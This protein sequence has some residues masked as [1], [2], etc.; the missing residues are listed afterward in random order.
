[1]LSSDFHCKENDGTIWFPGR[2]RTS[3][4]CVHEVGVTVYGVQ[5]V[6]HVQVWPE[7]QIVPSFSL[8]W[9]SD[10]STKHYL[11]QMLLAINWRYLQA[12][13]NSRMRTKV[14]YRFIQAHFIEIHQIFVKKKVG[15]FSNIEICNSLPSL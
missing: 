7:N 1:M 10:E 3:D 15:Y 14:Q 12:G 9:K 8:Q 6:P 11:T 13:K 4:Y 5:H 2:T